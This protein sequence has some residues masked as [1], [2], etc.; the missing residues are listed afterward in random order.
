MVPITK[1]EADQH[2]NVLSPRRSVDPQ[3]N[4]NCVTGKLQVRRLEAEGKA[5][6]LR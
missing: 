5:D 2:F 3:F 4:G 1:R 6:K